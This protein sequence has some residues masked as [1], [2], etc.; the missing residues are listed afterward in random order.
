M[1]DGRKNNGG[2]K[3]AGRKPKV[4]EQALIERLSPLD[5]TAHAAL[6]D[7]LEN[8]QPWAVKLFF[9]YR[10]GKPKQQ[11]DVTTDGDKLGM[12][13]LSI[14]VIAPKVSE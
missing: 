7:G 3:T 6:R 2:H 9:E 8:N 4:S 1:S 10:F 5:E 13:Q 14:E 11:I 12:S